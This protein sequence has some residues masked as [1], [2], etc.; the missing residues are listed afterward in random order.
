MIN[1]HLNKDFGIVIVV[2]AL[3]GK[4]DNLVQLA[5][6]HSPSLSPKQFDAFI[7]NGERESAKLFVETLS[8]E[9]LDPVLIDPDTS[10]W[11]IITDD[12]HLDANP[13]VPETESKCKSILL[14]MIENGS[15][16]V[17]L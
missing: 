1:E 4:T 13:L 12:M 7:S 10:Y 11:P 3:K 16:P 14:P 5:K 15:I 17:Q 2:S 8:N 9:S 6:N